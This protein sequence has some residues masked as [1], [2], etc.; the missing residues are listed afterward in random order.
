VGVILLS[1][2]LDW[3]NVSVTNEV[4]QPPAAQA[5]E[6]YDGPATNPSYDVPDEPADGA[7]YAVKKEHVEVKGLLTSGGIRFSSSASSR[8]SPPTPATSW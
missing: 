5:Q 1:Q 4:A 7:D 3:A 6:R 8:A 2:A